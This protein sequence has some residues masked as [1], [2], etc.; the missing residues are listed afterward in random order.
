MGRKRLRF[1]YTGASPPLCVKKSKEIVVPGNR[2]IQIFLSPLQIASAVGFMS[3]G[4]RSHVVTWLRFRWNWGT[5]CIKRENGEDE[6]IVF[7]ILLFFCSCSTLGLTVQL[8]CLAEE[9]KRLAL[10]AVARCIWSYAR[11]ITY[12]GA[13]ASQSCFT[14]LQT[15]LAEVCC[16][17]C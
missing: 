6:E 4:M 1:H 5:A 16:P 14:M 15:M 11:T 2:R 8:L 7:Q 3:P 17:E 10:V 12:I 13:N 9:V